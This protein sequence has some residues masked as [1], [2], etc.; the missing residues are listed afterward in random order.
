MDVR[1]GIIGLGGIASKF[2]TDLADTPGGELYGVAS[3]SSER[4]NEFAAK[5][6][7]KNIYENYETLV[8]DPNIDIVYIAVTHNWHYDVIK[9]CLENGRPVLCEKP[10]VLHEKQAAELAVLAKEKNLLL[11][12]AMWTRCNPAV[13]K[14][15]EWI[16]TGRIGKLRFI[17]ASFCFSSPYNPEH[18]LYN[19]ALAGGALYDVG[20]YVIEFASG[21]TGENPD[22]VSGLLS[23]AP[24][25]VDDFASISL[26]YPGGAL[27]GL[28]CGLT[29]QTRQDAWIYGDDGHVFIEN[30]YAADSCQLYDN[31]QNLV[32]R[33]STEHGGR[34]IYEIAHVIDLIRTGQK[35][36]ALIPLR[37]T[38]ATAKVFDTLLG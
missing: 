10:M 1:F 31:R 18:R 8:R 26:S 13:R 28:S 15:R 6:G 30:F 24:N 3:K 19:P 21:M 32:D 4:A 27:A 37:D 16:E 23:R 11:M 36:S 9:L 5:F 35:E 25:G 17:N 22:A 34:F 14:A 12:E 20:V 38:I 7:A 2:A 33:F 29:A